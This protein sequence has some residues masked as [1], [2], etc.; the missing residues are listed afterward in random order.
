MLDGTGLHIE[1]RD[2]ELAITNPRDPE[3]GHVYIA[4]DDAYVT[5]EHTACEYWGELEAF[6]TGHDRTITADKI[7]DTLN[8]RM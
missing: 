2:R 5:W 8:G 1:Q 4:Y 3:K 6:S 7:I